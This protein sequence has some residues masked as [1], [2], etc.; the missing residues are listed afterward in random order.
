VSRRTT[1]DRDEAVLAAARAVAA[2]HG[3]SLGAAV[4]ELARRGLSAPP[5]ERRRGFPVLP[6][7]EGGHVVDELVARHRDGD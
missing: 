1:L 6:V 2:R 4:S 5:V 7:P 3:R